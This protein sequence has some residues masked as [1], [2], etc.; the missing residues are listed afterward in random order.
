MK[1]LFSTATKAKKWRQT[2]VTELT[3]HW[4]ERGLGM[5][6]CFCGNETPIFHCTGSKDM[7]ANRGHW[8]DRTLDMTGRVR[9]VATAVHGAG[10]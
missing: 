9:S 6:G 4:T 3:G 1:R 10:R 5:T 2:E 7:E 8:I